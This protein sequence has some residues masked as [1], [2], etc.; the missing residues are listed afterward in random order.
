MKY[1][2]TL[3]TIILFGFLLVP[4]VL[5]NLAPVLEPYPAVLLPGAGVIKLTQDKIGFTRPA[6]YG[7]AAGGGDWTRLSP[8]QL[9][10]PLPPEFFPSLAQRYFGLSPIDPV[11]Y[12]IRWSGITFKINPHKITDDDVKNAKQWFRTRLNE[13]GYDD[14]AL[15]IAQEL[16]TF[17]LSDGAELA[18][19]CLDD[20]VFEL[21]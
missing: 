6:I 3:Y 11:G 15:R 12:S 17:R 8:L 10:Q 18:V 5:R 16:V 7:R 21:R 19:R 20:K 14:S 9:L 1:P 4:F 2:N 13:R